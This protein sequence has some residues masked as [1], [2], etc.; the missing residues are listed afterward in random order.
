MSPSRPTRAALAA[1]TLAAGLAGTAQAGPQDACA[2]GDFGW[3]AGA[4][5]TLVAGCFDQDKYYQ[6]IATTLPAAWTARTDNVDVGVVVANSDAH[7]IEFKEFE[8]AAL[9][10]GQAYTIRGMVQVRDIAPKHYISL[11]DLDMDGAFDANGNPFNARVIKRIYADANYSNLLLELESTGNF[12]FGAIP[13]S[14]QL[15]FEDTITVFGGTLLTI[16]NSFL[17]TVPEPASAALVLLALG[18]LAASRRRTGAA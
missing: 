10:L 12:V 2:A 13:L 17:Q 1:L 3:S 4:A 18:G 5:P 6:G 14:K 15:W 8:D 9:V 7:F 16:E 11:I